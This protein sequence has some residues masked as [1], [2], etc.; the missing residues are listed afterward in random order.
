MYITSP[1][2]VL[3]QGLDNVDTGRSVRKDVAREIQLLVG[4]DDC[5]VI[6]TLQFHSDASETVVPL[7]QALASVRVKRLP[8]E[9]VH[10]V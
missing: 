2:S 10:K 3:D 8:T 1:D 9:W 7:V 5:A 4:S 6:E